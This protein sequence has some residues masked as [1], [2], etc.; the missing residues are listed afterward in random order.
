M[1]VYQLVPIVLLALL[2]MAAGTANQVVH[3]RGRTFSV[4]AVTTPRGEPVVFLNDDTVPHNV[5]STSPENAFDLGAQSPGSATPVRFD[6]VGVVLVICAIHP[7]MRMT[8]TVT[9]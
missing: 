7:R 6:R 2:S 5:M 8:I 3:Q 1:R 9:N 4:D